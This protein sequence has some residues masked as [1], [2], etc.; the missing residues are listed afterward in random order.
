MTPIQN[1][2]LHKFTLF[3]CWCGFAAALLVGG[4]NLFFALNSFI[5]GSSILY[6]LLFNLAPV[7]F[8]GIF[9][10]LSFWLF[11]RQKYTLAI[12]ASL[13]ILMNLVLLYFFAR[14]PF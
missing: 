8:V 11:G 4:A 12:V 1:S 13:V 14:P 7:V 9:S 3:L 10:K 6:V 5:A 2:A